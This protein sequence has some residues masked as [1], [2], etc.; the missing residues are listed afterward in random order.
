MKAVSYS[1]YPWK[2]E[3]W[4]FVLTCQ[5]CNTELRI[6]WIKVK[7][8]LED[9]FAFPPRDLKCS[10][11]LQDPPQWEAVEVFIACA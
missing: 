9:F 3:L 8:E 4:L 2:P 11:C 10:I 6:P 1:M 7:L 5:G